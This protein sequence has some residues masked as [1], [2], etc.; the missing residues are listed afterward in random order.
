VIPGPGRG[1]PR[2][3]DVRAGLA[4][5]AIEGRC[6]WLTKVGLKIRATRENGIY[7]GTALGRANSSTSGRRTDPNWARGAHAQDL[8]GLR[9]CVKLLHELI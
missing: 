3:P 4:G 5:L 1:D 2:R 7:D 8:E 9:R 6:A